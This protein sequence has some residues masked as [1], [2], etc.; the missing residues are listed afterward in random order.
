M[1]FT[2]ILT[3]RGHCVQVSRWVHKGSGVHV[4]L[5]LLLLADVAVGGRG[6]EAS[7]TS[8][9]LVGRQRRIVSRL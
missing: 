1:R 3:V 4:L 8:L 2:C 5:L 6:P 7:D 9:L